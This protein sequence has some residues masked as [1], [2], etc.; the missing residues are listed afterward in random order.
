M[1]RLVKK[2]N[3][4]QVNEM[5]SYSYSRFTFNVSKDNFVEYAMVF[6]IFVM[7]GFSKAARPTNTS[8]QATINSNSRDT[9][10]YFQLLE[11]GSVIMI[12]LNDKPKNDF[13]HNEEFHNFMKKV[14]NYFRDK[15]EN[16]S[17]YSNNPYV[18]RLVFVQDTSKEIYSIISISYDSEKLLLVANTYF[19]DNTRLLSQGGLTSLVK[20]YKEIFDK[21]K[22]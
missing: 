16:A 15:L 9:K 3:N 4:Q 7:E 19:S 2:N 14:T 6:P 5:A 18:F 8:F 1:V 21:F 11:N 22:L 13:S 17:S 20:N 12:S 10:G